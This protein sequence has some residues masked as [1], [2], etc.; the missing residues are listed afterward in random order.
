M[1]ETRELGEL[2]AE[3]AR[4]VALLESHGIPWSRSAPHVAPETEPTGLGSDAKIALF[5]RLFQGREDVYAVRWESKAGRSGYAP[6]CANE[7][8]PGCCRTSADF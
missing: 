5:R 2:R 3:H 7:W 4:L 6:A 8:R 1:S